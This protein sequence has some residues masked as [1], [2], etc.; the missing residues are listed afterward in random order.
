MRAA[1]RKPWRSLRILDAVVANPDLRLVG[2]AYLAFNIAEWGTWIAILVFAYDV[3][4]ATAAGLVALIQ[5]APAAAF[6]PVAAALGDRYPRNRV[7]VAGYLAQTATMDATAILLLVDAPVP[8]IYA[9]AATAASAVT[10]TRPAQGALLPS[11]ARS[12]AEL[13]AANVAMGTIENVSFMLGPALAGLLLAV[14]HPGTVFAVMAGAALAAAIL[15]SAVRGAP[16]ARRGEP[17]G[18][19]FVGG[20]LHSSIEGIRALAADRPSRLLILLVGA[21]GLEF[22]ALDV[23]AVALAIGVLGMGPSGPGYLQ[24]ALGVGG[25]VGAVVATSL[26]GRS[27]LVPP[28]VWGFAGFGAA[29]ALIGLA[30]SR[31]GAFLCIAAAGLAR[32]VGDVAGRTLTQRVIPDEVLS[33]AFGALEG[34]MMGA[35]AAGSITAP[36]LIALLGVRGAFLVLGAALPVLFLAARRALRSLDVYAGPPAEA[37][38]LLRAIP[39]FSLLPPPVIEQL[40]SSLVEIE[41]GPGVTII[42]QGDVGDRF[43]IIAEGEVTV[44]ASGLEAVTLTGGDSFGEIALLRNVPRTASVVSRTPVRLY[45][46]GRER[47]LGAVTGHPATAQAADAVVRRRLGGR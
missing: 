25:L 16:S 11:L 26:V 44:S 20:V 5:L 27:R 2:L 38:A 40:A 23:L 30:P 17:D 36:G 1:V 45:A 12:P 28:L 22:G 15:A 37:L 34:L 6:A 47:F 33:R 9:L 43:Y 24:S 8:A 18:S 10:M 29:L 21:Q 4:G 39:M 13:T 31:A 14:V 19:G 7:L 32:T 3:G 42:R 35:L 41:H 46:L